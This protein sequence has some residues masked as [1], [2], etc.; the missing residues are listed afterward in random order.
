MSNLTAKEWNDKYPVGQSVFEVND[1]G[2]S[3]KTKTRSPAWDMC[4]SVVV[5]I[6]GRSGCYNLERISAR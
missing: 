2:K 1:F 5:N 6:D 4:G 3:R